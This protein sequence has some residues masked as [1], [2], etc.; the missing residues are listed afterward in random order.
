MRRHVLRATPAHVQSTL[1][2]M[3]AAS[4]PDILF[5]ALIDAGPGTESDR[6]EALRGVATQ[7]PV[8]R[9][10]FTGQPEHVVNYMFF[11]AEELRGIM[12]EMGFR[13]VDEMVGRVDRLD[14]TRMHRH[15]KANGINLDR[16]LHAPRDLLAGLLGR[17]RRDERRAAE[18]EEVR[19][20]LRGADG[21]RAG[22]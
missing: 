1:L 18:A 10:R 16:L 4:A 14:M 20:D 19:L 15:W 11:V 7:D 3:E 22:G 2:H 5:Q 21:V 17:G 13:T 8:L 6:A 9:A 12:A